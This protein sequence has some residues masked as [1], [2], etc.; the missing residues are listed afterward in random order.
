[1]VLLLKRSFLFKLY[2]I[3]K[4]EPKGERR[5]VGSLRERKGARSLRQKIKFETLETSK[6]P[7]SYV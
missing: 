3:E 1:M 6:K 2:M 7:G 4:R 5:L